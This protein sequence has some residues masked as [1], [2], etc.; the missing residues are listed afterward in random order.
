MKFPETSRVRKL[1]C[2]ILNER[3]V[4]VR[5]GLTPW[6]ISKRTGVMDFRRLIAPGTGF[7][8]VPPGNASDSLKGAT[9]EV[10]RLRAF[11]SKEGKPSCFWLRKG[12][13]TLQTN[14]R[15]MIKF[16]MKIVLARLTPLKNIH[17]QP[18]PTVIAHF[19]QAEAGQLL[20]PGYLFAFLDYLRTCNVS[21]Q[22]AGAITAYMVHGTKMSVEE[23]KT[24]SP[25][26]IVFD[27]SRQYVMDFRSGFAWSVA[28]QLY[29]DGP[30]R[31]LFWNA[32]KATI[33]YGGPR[34]RDDLGEAVER[35]YDLFFMTRPA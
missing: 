30:E 27:P 35:A 26:K 17:K 24:T 34:D 31:D 5:P 33:G 7:I 23:D 9:I 29:A 6:Q 2:N 14:E 19:N 13:E 21:P 11:L 4:P 18:P 16:L 22:K 28:E 12:E 32:A 1:N 10:E 8:I 3:A 20:N 25:E 15:Q